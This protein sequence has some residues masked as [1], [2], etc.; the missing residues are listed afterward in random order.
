MDEEKAN[1]RNGSDVQDADIHAHTHTDDG[2]ITSLEDVK[3]GHADMHMHT[4]IEGGA[5]GLEDMGRGYSNARVEGQVR[6]GEDVKRGSDDEEADEKMCSDTYT[7]K[8]GE[9]DVRDAD[10]RVIEAG[11]ETDGH[12]LSNR[13]D[14]R[15]MDALSVQNSDKNKDDSESE[16]KNKYGHYHGV[17]ADREVLGARTHADR[18]EKHV[19][20]FFYGMY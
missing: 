13:H 15:Q 2:G 9:A 10:T 20:G 16:Q 8:N 6:R 1:E 11:T 12:V 3:N 4:R 14:N 18:D 17:D 5:T 7:H 19:D